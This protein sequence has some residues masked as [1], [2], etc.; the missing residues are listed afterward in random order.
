VKV[1]GDGKVSEATAA[2]SPDP[3]LG[4]CVVAAVKRAT[5]PKTQNGG[6]FYVPYLF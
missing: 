5:F 2:E 4:A 3:A 1:G 6:S